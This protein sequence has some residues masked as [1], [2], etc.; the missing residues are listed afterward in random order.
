M[1]LLKVTKM[2][3]QA[4][5][6]FSNVLRIKKVDGKIL[7]LKRYMK[8]Q[9]CVLLQF[10]AKTSKAERGKITLWMTYYKEREKR[11]VKC[12]LSVLSIPV[13]ELR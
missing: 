3:F 8:W 5:H 12:L 11:E 2:G 9:A 1:L 10:A 6:T 7:Y 4:K 13:A